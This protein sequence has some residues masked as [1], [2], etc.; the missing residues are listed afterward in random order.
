MFFLGVLSLIQIIFLPGLILVKLLK[1]PDGI[2]QKI[3]YAFGLSLIFNQLYVVVI[4]HLKINFPIV[5]YSLFAI[6]VV[7]FVY[8][9]S[10]DLRKPVYEHLNGW[11]DQF[12]IWV[13]SYTAAIESITENNSA[14]I[15]VVLFIFF[16]GLSIISISWTIDILIDKLGTVFTIWDSVVSWN[17]WAV[18]WFSNTHPQGTYRYPQLIPTNFSITYSFM[19]SSTLQFFAKGFMPLFAVFFLLL[20]LDLGLAKKNYAYLIGLVIS[21]FILKRFYHSFISSG[22]VDVPLIFF[23][24]LT[25]HTLLKAS[26]SN[27]DHEKIQYSL[28]GFIFGAGAALTKQNGLY[29]FAVYP[30]LAY[31]LVFQSIESLSTKEKIQKLIL[32]FGL[33][34]GLLLPWYVFNELR[35]LAGAKTNVLQLLSQEHHGGR[36]LVERLLKAYKDLSIYVY[37]YPIVIVALPI[38]QKEIRKIIIF[39]LIPYSLI[40]AFFFSS[41]PRNLSIGLALLGFASGHALQGLIDIALKIFDRLNV[42]KVPILVVWIVFFTGLLGVQILVPDS[43]L[44]K[45]QFDQQRLIL[46]SDVND[47]IYQYFDNKGGLEQVFTNYPLRF[48]PGFENMQVDIGGFEDYN[49]YRYK[50][51]QYPEVKYMLIELYKNNGVVLN[52]IHDEIAHGNMQVIFEDKK[53]IFVEILH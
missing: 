11:R 2:I 3:I 23:T 32:Y 44:I 18:E 46:E 15:S 4:T 39:V 16:L 14:I 30:F 48:L 20:I 51:E 42:K 37:L 12:Q 38:I 17:H 6:E 8:Y 29:I 27:F 13:R 19:R 26:G 33:A 24:F 7:L 31:L 22:Y 36:S 52:E 28:F 50:R 53:Y 21:Q 1:I 34:V 9:Y 25:V 47:Q 49:F 35:I 5:H 40:W 45:K 10:S 43:D 41:H